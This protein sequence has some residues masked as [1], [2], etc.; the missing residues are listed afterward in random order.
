MHFSALLML[1]L[2]AEQVLAFIGPSGRHS[3]FAGLGELGSLQKKGRLFVQDGNG[4]P[5]EDGEISADET[6]EL[7]EDPEV[8]A[9]KEEI[10][11]LES[12]LKG[13]KS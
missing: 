13:K 9:L 7:E 11:N 10:A 5:N 4:L 6:P 2:A 12:E 8:T 3:S 1:A